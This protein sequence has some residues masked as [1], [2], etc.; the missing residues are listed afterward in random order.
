MALLRWIYLRKLTPIGSDRE[1]R[2]RLPLGGPQ[3]G[4]RP[5]APKAEASL[6]KP[7][8]QAERASPSGEVSAQAR[9]CRRNRRHPSGRVRLEPDRVRSE[10]T[11]KDAFLA[12]IRKSK[13]VFYNTVV[14]QAQTIE[15]AADR[16]I[17]TF[18]PAQRALRD[19][20][21]QNRAWLEAIAQ[22]IAGRKIAVAA[23][24]ATG[25][26][27]RSPRQRASRSA[28]GRRSALREALADAGVQALLGSSRRK[29]RDVEEM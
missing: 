18:S 10:T 13:A 4:D 14:S 1:R 22:Q 27:R 7:A 8:T 9:R 15:A 12:E 26:P 5:L 25:P 23:G 2:V 17:F 11:F 29:Y 3:G 16:V 19:A 28:A 21:E 20:V 6:P 24:Q